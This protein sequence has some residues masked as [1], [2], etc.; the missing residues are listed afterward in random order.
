[1]YAFYS[2]WRSS[3]SILACVPFMTASVLLLVKLNSSAT[4][5]KNASYIKAGSI[6]TMSVSS[7]RTILS[8]NAVQVVIDKF[9]AATEEAYRG[10]VGQSHLLG[11]AYGSQMASMLLSYVPVTLYGSYLMYNA[12]RDTGCDPSGGVL[13][14]DTCDPAG[15]DVF[16]SLMGITVAASVL[17]QVCASSI[18][19][20]CICWVVERNAGE[21]KLFCR[22]FSLVI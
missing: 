9:V 5:R 17:P 12:V 2:S 16:G 11:F 4:E 20:N 13:G 19:M 22:L 3:L 1:M 7:I 21:L 18:G 15:K 8:L 6:V 14:V 10:A